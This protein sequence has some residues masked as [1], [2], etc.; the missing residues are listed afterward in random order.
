M[1]RKSFIVNSILTSLGLFTGKNLATASAPTAQLKVGDT[2]NM[3]ELMMSL[4]LQLK[5]KIKTL[6]SETKNN[7]QEPVTFQV[8]LK[9]RYYHQ[10]HGK[11]SK[12]WFCFQEQ[13]LI[14]CEYS[15]KTGRLKVSI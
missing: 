11:N 13:K 9:D 5:E 2:D 14:D 12:G 15:H 3:S 6:V 7:T 1:K 10:K 8:F 4:E